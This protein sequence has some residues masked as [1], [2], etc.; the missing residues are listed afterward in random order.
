[1]KFYATSINYCIDV[2]VKNLK[3]I[4]DLDNKALDD[5]DD[6][7]YMRLMD[8]EGVENAKY[9]GHFGPYIFVELDCQCDNGETWK[10]IENTIKDYIKRKR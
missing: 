2:P 10:L 4:L 5:Y 7:L 3:R 9:D 1:M 8:I 6:V